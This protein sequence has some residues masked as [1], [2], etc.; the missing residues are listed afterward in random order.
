MIE[1]RNVTKTYSDSGS[2]LPALRGVSA[3]FARGQFTA[4]TGP[5]GCGKS[6]LLH[7]LGGMDRPDSGDILF[8]GGSLLTGDDKILSAYRLQKVGVVFQFFNLLPTLTALE[9][10]MLPLMLAQCPVS[11]ARARARELLTR[12]GMVHRGNH[13]PH[14]LSGG[15]MQRTAIARALIHRPALVLADEP[16]GNLDSKTGAEILALF[17]DTVAAGGATLILVTHSAEVAAAAHRQIRMHDGQIIGDSG[18]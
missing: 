10:A 8:E 15:E 9:N 6:T 7:L 11:E 13:Y 17:I 1:I 2:G 16:T 3:Q 4:I 5:S 12:T 14:Q 18:P